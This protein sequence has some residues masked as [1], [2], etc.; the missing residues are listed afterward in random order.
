VPDAKRKVSECAL[1]MESKLSEKDSTQ[2]EWDTMAEDAGVIEPIMS[3]SSEE[4]MSSFAYARRIAAKDTKERQNDSHQSDLDAPV[5]GLEDSSLDTD[6]SD[7]NERTAKASPKKRRESPGSEKLMDSSRDEELSAP[8]ESSGDS[9]VTDLVGNTSLV[10]SSRRS[11]S[12][13]GMF[14]KS[15]V[16]S[17]AAPVRVN[18]SSVREADT[19]VRVNKSKGEL[20]L[21]KPRR[22]PKESANRSEGVPVKH[23]P[24]RRPK[25][26]TSNEED[27][28]V[29]PRK[30][31]KDSTQR[32]KNSYSRGQA[33]AEAKNAS[34][35]T[36]AKAKKRDV[37][38]KKKREVVDDDSTDYSGSVST[39]TMGSN[40]EDLVTA[41]MDFIDLDLDPFEEDN[42]FEEEQHSIGSAT[43]S[44]D[45]E[46]TG[47]TNLDLAREA[48]PGAAKTDETSYN[49]CHDQG[50][51]EGLCD[52]I[53]MGGVKETA[54][55][56]DTEKTV[57]DVQPVNSKPKKSKP[58]KKDEEVEDKVAPIEPANIDAVAD[59]SESSPP[60]GLSDF[61]DLSFFVDLFKEL[62]P[63][64]KNTGMAPKATKSA[65]PKS[66]NVNQAFD[67][68]G[69]TEAETLF[70][71]LLEDDANDDDSFAG[72]A[73]ILMSTDTALN[74]LRAQ[75]PNFDEPLNESQEKTTPQT[76]LVVDESAEVAR[77]VPEKSPLE[78]WQQ[79]SD[80]PFMEDGSRIIS[81][82]VKLRK[83]VSIPM[84]EPILLKRLLSL[85]KK[86]SLLTAEE[87]YLTPPVT[88]DDRDETELKPIYSASFDEP[89]P[90]AR[91]KKKL[92]FSPFQEVLPYPPNDEAFESFES[93]PAN[94]KDEIYLCGPASRLF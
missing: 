39:G 65:D 49:I 92:S 38:R 55:A 14:S 63:P 35:T 46:G 42:P 25:D 58:S 79:F 50:S 76:S 7:A 78:D 60:L 6:A 85:D 62:F 61:F 24:Y 54:K 47:A 69:D 21:V 83:T 87:Q 70:D 33:R 77:K 5:P 15:P 67:S 51:F 91:R 27:V 75:L 52:F 90:D 41:F 12:G 29:K 80:S 16:R 68:L 20:D 17:P 31:S 74:D 89:E 94:E 1:R 28:Q 66:P 32:T 59:S 86:C 13:A 82:P 73:S 36:G 56:K 30:L 44:I 2:A 18:E 11:K 34:M 37:P 8:P 26:S 84:E 3:S 93:A 48:L 53:A 81:T 71:D 19:P 9:I 45:S 10:G 43:A 22:V 23:R 4:Y 64:K 72:L 88:P 57:K 40:G